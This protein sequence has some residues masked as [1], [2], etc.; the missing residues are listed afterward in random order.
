VRHRKNDGQSRI[1]K[2]RLTGRTETTKHEQSVDDDGDC[3]ELVSM[4][5][6]SFDPLGV[7][8]NLDEQ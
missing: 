8:M 1:S 6:G 7:L 2:G 4:S 5:T 3:F